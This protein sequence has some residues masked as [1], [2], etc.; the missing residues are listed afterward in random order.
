MSDAL[1][2]AGVGVGDSGVSAMHDVAEGGVYSACFEMCTAA[3]LGMEIGKESIRVS[4]ETGEICN[5]FGLDPY[6]TLG[7]GA[8]LIACIPENTERILEVLRSRGTEASIIG[9]FVDKGRGVVSVDAGAKNVLD[10]G[11]AD[12]Y[13]EASYKATAAKWD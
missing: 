8:M 5:L 12:P 13:W 2:A 4:P 10:G 9:Q 11:F 1:A 3:S 7:E 6:I